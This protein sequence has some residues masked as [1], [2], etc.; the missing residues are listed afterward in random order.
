MQRGPE[1]SMKHE[2]SATLYCTT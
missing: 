1:L 2:I